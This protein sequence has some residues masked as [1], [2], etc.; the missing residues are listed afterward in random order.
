MKSLFGQY[1]K[2]S[3][4]AMVIII[5]LVY[6]FS[7]DSNGFIGQLQKTAPKVVYGKDDNEVTLDAINSR[8]NPVITIATVKLHSNN[9]YSFIDF[10]HVEFQD[11]NATDQKIF[12]KKVEK[13]DG[14]IIEETDSLR[15]EKGIYKVL[16]RAEECYK[17]VTKYAEKTASFVVD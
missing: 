2:L 3:I 15:V 16:Y 7:A 14:S 6:V 1:G 11:S 5:L 4:L 8:K 13:P 10:A 9:V 17:G 12:V